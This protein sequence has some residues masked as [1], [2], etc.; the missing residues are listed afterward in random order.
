VA[1]MPPPP[2]PAPG[3]GPPPPP[4][5]VMPPQQWGAMPSQQYGAVGPSGGR[6]AGFWI[7]FVAYIIDS[8]ITGVV[9]FVLLVVTKP[10]TC[11]TSDGTTCIAGTTMISPLFWVLIL[12]VAVYFIILW[13][14]GGTL[15]QRM[16]GMRVVNATTG[17]N[18]GLGR[19]ILRYLGFIIS[20]IPIYLG[21]IWAGFDARKQGWHDKIAGSLVVRPG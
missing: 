4:Y 8:I 15:G 1:S 2:P 19:S 14:V 17:G 12:I 20:T 18:L 10:I 11:E 9:L 13:A 7:R 5:G 21:L 6:Y 3:A 16:L